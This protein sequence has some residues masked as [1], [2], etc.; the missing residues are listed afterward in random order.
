ME[1][2]P[3]NV[4]YMEEKENIRNQNIDT[5]FFKPYFYVYIATNTKHTTLVSGLSGSLSVILSQWEEGY[6]QESK[7]CTQMVYWE[8]FI[9]VQDAIDR[10]LK[11]RKM[12]FRRKAELISRH[13]PEWQSLNEAFIAM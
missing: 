8:R 10:E 11:I 1:C 9:D 12:S 13:N 2:I 7:D 4:S 5:L 3:I 6:G